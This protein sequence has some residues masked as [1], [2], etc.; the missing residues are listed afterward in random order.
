MDSVLYSNK[1]KKKNAYSVCLLLHHP[2]TKYEYFQVN[3]F[4]DC[5]ITILHISLRGVQDKV[6]ILIR[7][8]RISTNNEVTIITT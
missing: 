2:F 1:T 7:K 6:S 8:D 4:V 5:N 3:I